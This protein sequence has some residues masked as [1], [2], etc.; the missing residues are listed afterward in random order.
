MEKFK[1]AVIDT[2]LDIDTLS[3]NMRDKIVIKD[4]FE[5]D[6]KAMHSSMVINTLLKY[7]DADLIEKI[8]LYNVFVEENKGSGL[9][10]ISALEDV[11]QKNEVD[12]L[13]MSMTLNNIDRYEY[14][15]NLCQI[16]TALG[17]TVIAADSNRIAKDK[18]YPFSF[19]CVYGISQGAFVDKPFFSVYDIETKHILGDAAPEFIYCGEKKYCLF[20]GT[21]KATPKFLAVIL[22]AFSEKNDRSSKKI[23]EWVKT[24]SLSADVNIIHKIKEN[25]SN[26]VYCK[27][28][29]DTLYRYISVCPI[30]I[31]KYGELTPSFY[32]GQLESNDL[33][34]FLV[35]I[36]KK[37]NIDKRPEDMRFIDFSSLGNFCAYIGRQ[38]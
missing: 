30:D 12:F 32:L 27:K 3:E 24:N 1:I 36:L 38:I 14:T 26:T 5:P 18:Y 17:I 7:T 10:T 13:I 19:E 37:F 20:G 23:R 11:I 8:Y 15:E 28:V 9:A 33:A 34:V 29:Y 16:I 22:N 21:S 2:A 35:Y 6:N 25:F 4:Y 31:R